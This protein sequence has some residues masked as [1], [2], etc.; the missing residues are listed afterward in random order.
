M[1]HDIKRPQDRLR[2]TQTK[3]QKHTK[4]TTKTIVT[5]L[6]VTALFLAATYMDT[7]TGVYP[8]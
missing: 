6:V 4:E 7:V 8:S 5:I 2:P 1:Y 3:K